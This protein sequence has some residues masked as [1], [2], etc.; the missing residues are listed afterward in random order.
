MADK[1]VN[2][3]N[4]L[5]QIFYKSEKLPYDK[6]VAPAYML[7]MWLSHD[8]SLID[9]V[10]K[11]NSLQFHLKDDIIYLYYMSKVPKGRRFIKW[12]KKD[13]KDKNIEKE[14]KNL[15]EKSKLSKREAMMVAKFKEI[16]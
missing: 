16:L 5:N 10:N 13:Q 2:I 6:K 3:F 15:M 8:V 7:S 1:E 14:I 9:I 11:I 12:T 4:Y